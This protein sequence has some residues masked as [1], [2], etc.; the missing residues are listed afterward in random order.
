MRRMRFKNSC[1]GRPEEHR[2]NFAVSRQ[3]LFH[4]TQRLP[5]GDAQPPPARE[6]HV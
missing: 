3:S 6:V 1:A 4:A 5:D 2:I